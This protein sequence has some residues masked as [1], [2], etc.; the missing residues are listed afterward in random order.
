[1]T[2]TFVNLF[3]IPARRDDAF[4]ALWREVN[5]YMRTKSGYLEH[6]MHRAL[7]DDARYRYVNIALWSS[8]QAW[9]DAH[10][11]GF[12]ALV[13]RPEWAEFRS[14][15]GLYEVVHDNAQASG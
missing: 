2:V 13:G 9:R 3:E 15:P 1:M 14:T 6:R 5:A 7:L 8:L 11:D 10:D 4:F 12:R